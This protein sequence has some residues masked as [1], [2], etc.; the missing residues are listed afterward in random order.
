MKGLNDLNFKLINKDDWERKHYYNLYFF[1]V[2][3][4]YSMT[5]KLDITNI[6]NKNIKLYPAMLYFIT[7]IVNLYE[8][9]RTAIN[10]N[11]EVGIYSDMSPSYTIFN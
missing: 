10:K 3:C 4:T 9:F 7:T 1:N 11:G 2:P 5:V 8:E 6:E